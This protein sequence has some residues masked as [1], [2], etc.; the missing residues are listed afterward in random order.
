MLKQLEERWNII[1]RKLEDVTENQIEFLQVKNT[2]SRMKKIL[3]SIN[4]ILST[5]E[6]N[7]VNL[8]IEQKNY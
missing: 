4:W 1:V 5:A 3:N 7:F 8:Q 2:T 6:K